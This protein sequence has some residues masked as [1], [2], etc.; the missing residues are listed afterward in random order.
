M[1]KDLV[2][3]SAQTQKI[4]SGRIYLRRWRQTAQLAHL[5]RTLRIAASSSHRT[6]L[7]RHATRLWA[8]SVES[9]KRWRLH[10]SK[11]SAA[12]VLGLLL[13]WKSWKDHRALCRK[14][15]SDRVQ[16]CRRLN[17][18]STLRWWSCEVRVKI[19]HRHII[20]TQQQRS[21]RESLVT[22]LRVLQSKC[23]EADSWNFA[24]A[25]M[26]RRWKLAV[27][28]GWYYWTHRRLHRRGR[29]C[30]H[31]ATRV[32]PQIRREVIGLW[33]SYIRRHQ[34]QEIAL[35]RARI[36]M[37]LSLKNRTFHAWVL[38]QQYTARAVSVL[39]SF[40]ATLDLSLLGECVDDWRESVA[41]VFRDRGMLSA[42]ITFNAR[43]IL[44]KHFECM[45]ILVAA[46]RLK[47]DN[48]VQADRFHAFRYLT[49]YWRLWRA[50]VPVV[51]KE[52]EQEHRSVEH[53][54]RVLALRT[55]ARWRDVVS[56]G[57]ACRCQESQV[58]RNSD[59][60]VT[61]TFWTLWSR[62]L[63]FLRKKRHAAA[64][65][66]CRGAIG[67]RRL[68][69]GL[70]AWAKLHGAVVH[71]KFAPCSFA[72]TAARAFFVRGALS[73][74][75]RDKV[76]RV[77][78]AVRRSRL[79]A[80]FRNAASLWRACDFVRTATSPG[81]LR[82]VFGLWRHFFLEAGSVTQQRVIEGRSLQGRLKLGRGLRQ[83]YHG[84]LARRDLRSRTSKVVRA[85]EAMVKWQCQAVQH[86]SLGQ[87]CRHTERDRAME[88]SQ[89]SLRHGFLLRVCFD[90]WTEFQELQ[91]H[92][93]SVHQLCDHYRQASLL[94]S[95][96]RSWSTLHDR[97]LDMA[98]AVLLWAAGVATQQVQWLMWLWRAC[99][100]QRQRT[101]QAAEEVLQQRRARGVDMWRCAQLRKQAE[102]HAVGRKVQSFCR[103]ILF[104]WLRQTLEDQSKRRQDDRATEAVI[105]NRQR[106]LIDLWIEARRWH[107][108]TGVA[109]AWDQQMTRRWLLP[110]FAS[111]RS[112]QA[113][114]LR[115]EVTATRVGALR[116][117]TFLQTWSQLSRSVRVRPSRLALQTLVHWRDA[118]RRTALLRSVAAR[119]SL[120]GIKDFFDTF[121]A[122]WKDRCHRRET[123]DR[124]SLK[125]DR[126]CSRARSVQALR[127]WHT[128]VGCKQE[129]PTV[130]RRIRRTSL[131][132]CLTTWRST[133]TGSKL[134]CSRVE[135]VR[136]AGRLV[137]FRRWALA[138]Q[139]HME[140]A[141][142]AAMAPSRPIRRAI[143]RLL[144]PRDPS[145][146]F[147]VW[148]SYCQ[149][150]RS[151]REREA[152]L[153]GKSEQALIGRTF[154]QLVD[155][156]EL[157]CSSYYAAL[158]LNRLQ[159][160]RFV[161]AWSRV[162]TFR[163]QLVARL[164]EV[165]AVEDDHLL[166]W[167]IEQWTHHVRETCRLAAVWHG[168]WTH[169]SRALL[170]SWRGYVRQRQVMRRYVRHMRAT[171]AAM[172]NKRRADLLCLMLSAGLIRRCFE[173]YAAWTQKVSFIRVRTTDLETRIRGERQRRRLCG[174]AVSCRAERVMHEARRSLPMAAIFQAWVSVHSLQRRVAW[175]TSRNRARLLHVVFGAWAEASCG[176]LRLRS[177]SVETVARRRLAFTQH[178][179]HAWTR[180]SCEERS[181]R[182]ALETHDLRWS[183]KTLCSYVFWWRHITRLRRVLTRTAAGRHRRLTH[184]CWHAWLW[185][186]AISKNGRRRSMVLRSIRNSSDARMSFQSW[187]RTARRLAGARRLVEVLSWVDEQW[188]SEPEWHDR[189]VRDPAICAMF[190]RFATAFDRRSE[191]TK[192]HR[193]AMGPVV[194]LIWSRQQASV[195]L[196]RLR[197]YPQP[198]AL[199]W[200]PAGASSLLPQDSL[201]YKQTNMRLK[202]M[203]ANLEAQQAP[204]RTLHLF[205]LVSQTRA[206]SKRRTEADTL[207]LPWKRGFMWHTLADLMVVQH[208]GW[209]SRTH[210][211][212]FLQ[213]HEFDAD[214]RDVDA[215]SFT[216]TRSPSCT[217]DSPRFGFGSALSLG[218]S[219]VA[220]VLVN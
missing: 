65:E 82:A 52:R 9:W 209:P 22:T 193:E 46:G 93:H 126:G 162:V 105:Q 37:A 91:C 67:C 114:T 35:Q 104:A 96:F 144:L 29:L 142:L 84:M 73:R 113:L 112:F 54:D 20:A 186:G 127:W 203:L 6:N 197:G 56:H 50:G 199:G 196:G 77:R 8:L 216:E 90:H 155:V 145:M 72:R 58:A 100:L 154:S 181:R 175:T 31:L 118:S 1:R 101:V 192:L 99:I 106:H 171:T 115:G 160:S 23:A 26:R 57:R 138:K 5:H 213:R 34:R 94:K 102:S 11:K 205:S 43:W 44:F 178:V 68:L 76:S 17:K 151:T 165:K 30:D 86:W 15:S 184:D 80:A 124:N 78:A 75:E 19:K 107:R 201:Y 128:R 148:A 16:R 38:R 55:I 132:T 14:D 168:R 152:V 85:L 129:K 41:E 202:V 217:S 66:H 116:A 167:C 24:A 218:T 45:C 198:W 153:Q 117:T 150:K 135:T 210:P 122:Y 123:L 36:I 42:A 92:K 27:L 185:Q 95:A 187:R 97:T 88:A 211:S 139:H 134:D 188:L 174:W 164:V 170:S 2:Q 143:E 3:K 146:A 60:R 190:K 219:S 83:L 10:L 147:S 159:L 182:S 141:A 180:Y 131:R 18:V 64:F 172:R 220:G 120:L 125:L 12:R 110:S 25:H 62:R 70:R 21:V 173:A 79:R 87:L 98:E 140:K 40:T 206:S 32:H 133:A 136:R 81:L 204:N 119:W 137:L 177:L 183:H 74:I 33:V 4:V 149:R 53:G 169:W 156:Y 212:L 195:A 130:V 89:R 61:A 215:S 158:I 191:T 109:R 49:R 39:W 163:R 103:S 13:M 121:V 7:L 69:R 194:S 161:T 214:P 51:R 47:R 189:A 28:R 63:D 111:W 207:P 59:R 200:W 108:L 166:M 176:G 157:Q 48:L 71:V 179:L 208:P